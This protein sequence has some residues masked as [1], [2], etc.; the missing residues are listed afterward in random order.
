MSY[1]DDDVEEL[2][3]RMVDYQ[4]KM[5]KIKKYLGLYIASLIVVHYLAGVAGIGYYLYFSVGYKLASIQGYG[6]K[7]P[8]FVPTVIGWGLIV[9]LGFVLEVLDVI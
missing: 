7:H 6:L 8:F 9:P 2:R 1:S 3:S 5:P 4:G